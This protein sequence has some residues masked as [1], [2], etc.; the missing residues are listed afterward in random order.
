MNQAEESSAS[1][2]SPASKRNPRQAF[3]T[4]SAELTIKPASLAAVEPTAT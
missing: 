4:P 1:D 2:K 3:A